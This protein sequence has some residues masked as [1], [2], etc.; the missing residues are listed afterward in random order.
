MLRLGLFSS[1]IFLLLISLAS[2]Q[3]LVPKPLPKEPLEKYDNPPGLAPAA[4]TSPAL[5]SQFGPYTSYQVN[6][7]ANGNN[8][9][10]DAANEPSICVDPANGKQDEHR[11]ATVRPR[12]VKLSSGRVRIHGQWRQNMEFS[13][14]TFSA[15]IRAE[16]R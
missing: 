15:A 6:V 3:T 5:V 9:V 11:L 13:N 1:V 7:G 2:S 16:L 8:I 14:T 10:G 12:V 4:V